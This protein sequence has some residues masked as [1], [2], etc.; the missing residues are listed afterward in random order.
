MVALSGFPH[1][2][3]RALYNW[4][5]DRF[6]NPELVVRLDDVDF[7]ACGAENRDYDVV[8]EAFFSLPNHVMRIFGHGFFGTGITSANDARGQL[9]NVVAMPRVSYDALRNYYGS[10]KAVIV[11]L[12]EVDY[13][14][15]V[16][17]AIEAMACGCP[18][19]ATE[20]VGIAEYMMQIDPRLRVPPGDAD[21]MVRAIEAVNDSDAIVLSAW[22]RA[23]R[24]WIVAHCSLD[25]YV[26]SICDEMLNVEG[27]N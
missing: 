3:V 26:A 11:P 18:V 13:A 15:G 22:G 17:G 14:A 21:G 2:R 27:A 8:K 25:N 24:E 9:P 12:N 1:E 7:V 4:V 23:N 10:A 16:T 19:I 20:T 6:F 5:D